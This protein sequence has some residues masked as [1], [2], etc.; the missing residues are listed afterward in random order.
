MVETG[1]VDAA[2]IPSPL[3]PATLI[4]SPLIRS[5]LVPLPLIRS[6]LITVSPVVVAVAVWC[7]ARPRV[8][9]RRADSDSQ[10]K[11]GQPECTGDHGTSRYFLHIHREPLFA[12]PPAAQWGGRPH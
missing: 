4:W 3:V 5:P 8:R 12:R 10:R 9:G 11:G 1:I 2:L 7:P 6:S